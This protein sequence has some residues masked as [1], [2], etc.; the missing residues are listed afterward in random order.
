MGAGMNLYSIGQFAYRHRVTGGAALLLAMGAASAWYLNRRDN[1][2]QGKKPE[3]SK[4]SHAPHP[5]AR[6]TSSPKPGRRVQQGIDPGI[7]TY[8]NGIATVPRI[9]SGFPRNDLLPGVY[10]SA[11][12]AD[13][14]CDVEAPETQKQETQKVAPPAH[15]YDQAAAESE[16]QQE[17]LKSYAKDHPINTFSGVVGLYASS[18]RPI[19]AQNVA[20]NDPAAIP[21]VQN[22]QVLKP[23]PLAN[24]QYIRTLRDDS[25]IEM[26]KIHGDH[27]RKTTELGIAGS[28]RF[29]WD[30]VQPL[31][32]T[33]RR[34]AITQTLPQFKTTNFMGNEKK[35]LKGTL[36]ISGGVIANDPLITYTRSMIYP[37]VKPV[38]DCSCVGDFKAVAIGELAEVC[39]L[40]K[41]PV[42][43]K[44]STT[45]L[46]FGTGLN[47]FGLTG[48]SAKWS[49]KKTTLV[50]AASPKGLPKFK[51]TPVDEL[52]E[53]I[54]NV[55]AG[56]IMATYKPRENLLFGAQASKFGKENRLSLI[57]RTYWP[58]GT[59]AALAVDYGIMPNRTNGAQLEPMILSRGL[60]EVPVN[61]HL[62]VG[63][64]VTAGRYL[65]T[66]KNFA[67]IQ[68]NATYTSEK[69][70]VGINF[71][72]GLSSRYGANA[73]LGVVTNFK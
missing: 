41:A 47:E 59:N 42:L 66:N 43:R 67:D 51:P 25:D 29:H 36:S 15:A 53:P 17:F 56:T 63:A 55:A 13:Q 11:P 50:I 22:R 68:V 60:V 72:G 19:S 4:A 18:Y 69:L 49:A 40:A 23:M 2:G 58:G 61:K 34:L 26:V 8:S 28:W 1:A 52:P 6:A 65:G 35:E 57:G 10:T 33:P 27:A 39:K 9:K 5:R 12:Q 62:D 14:Q 71:A 20:P 70:P 44:P 64:M 7:Q 21:A 32:F 48:A 3:G 16:K 38:G 37:N 30:F 54:T 31:D 46:P 73:N 45:L 24:V